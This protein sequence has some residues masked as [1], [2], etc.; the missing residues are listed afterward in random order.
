LLVSQLLSTFCLFF[1]EPLTMPDPTPTPPFVVTE[2]LSKVYYKSLPSKPSLIATTKPGPFEV[3]TDPE[4]YS[5]PK[6][7]RPLG[8]HALASVWN[9]G[10][11]DS[12]RDTLN[13]MGVNWTSMDVLRI[14][15]DGESSSP[16]VVWIGVEFGSLS[17]EEG[18][19]V[20]HKCRTLTDCYGV[21]D[22]HVEIRESRVMRYC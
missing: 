15:E 20:A 5:V 21:Q 11:G 22:C 16:A 8:K 12:L 10:L 2:G 3:P 4:A 18:S 17:F 1:T 9:H 19:A 13:T 14:V 7:L 6:E